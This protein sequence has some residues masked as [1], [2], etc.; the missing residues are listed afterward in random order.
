M[1][2]RK[3]LL[4]QQIVFIDGG[5]RGNPGQSASAFSLSS[6]GVHVT[7]QAAYLGLA[8]NNVAE[9]KALQLFTDYVNLSLN[10]N[11]KQ[12]D[13]TNRR[14]LVLSDSKLLVNQMKKVWGTKDEN[15]QEIQDGIRR[16]IAAAGA[17]LSF[18][19]VPR[20]FNQEADKAVNMVLD[21]VERGGIGESGDGRAWTE[22]MAWSEPVICPRSEWESKILGP[23]VDTL[24][25]AAA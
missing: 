16:K 7:T 12:V 1:L 6:S 3:N 9:Y 17:D 14:F 22:P 8:T 19:Y 2:D 13:T 15:L 10:I 5:S 24:L 21:M 25:P 11:Q 23:A 20:R 4:H 18:F